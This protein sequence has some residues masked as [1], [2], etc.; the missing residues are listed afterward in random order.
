MKIWGS[1]NSGYSNYEGTTIS[2]VLK[3]SN[4]DPTGSGWSGTTIG[5][6]SPFSNTWATNYKETLGNANTTRYRYVWLELN[7]SGADLPFVC[8]AEFY[9]TLNGVESAISPSGLTKITSNFTLNLSNFADGNTNQNG[10]NSTYN[11]GAQSVA[12]CGLD[13]GA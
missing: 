4:T 9:Q 13:L 3:A 8:E 10:A 1:N 11:T 12:R 7:L 6:I 5:S 2:P